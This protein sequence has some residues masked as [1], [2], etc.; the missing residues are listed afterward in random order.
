M[1]RAFTL[2]FTYNGNTYVAVISQR[3][4]TTTIYLPDE[5]LHDVLPQ[6]R[7]S[8]DS[9]QGILLDCP[10][11]KKANDLIVSIL[12]VMNEKSREAQQE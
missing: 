3:S 9:Q 7:I 2:H 1:S 8:F 4:G 10:E 5:S 12:A 11:L 6:G